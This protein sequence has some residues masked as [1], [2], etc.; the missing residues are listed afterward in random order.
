MQTTRPQTMLRLMSGPA[1]AVLIASCL[2]SAALAAQK[3]ESLYEASLDINGD[4][5]AD[6]AVIVLFGPGRTDFH[7]L[8]KERYGLST[9]ERVE[10]WIFLGKGAQATDLA[11]TPDFVK[12]DIIDPE[13]TPW[14]QPLETNSSGSLMVSAAHQWGA[15][16]DWT[17]VLTI[18][19]RRGELVVAGYD[20]GWSWNTWRAD[21]SFQTLEGECAINFLTGKGT[22]TKDGGE[23]Q[24][25]DGAFE[26]VKLKDWNQTHRPAACDFTVND[27]DD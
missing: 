27:G 23:P 3:T 8:T 7:E 9:D 26:L 1:I 22:L 2:A 24:P 10:L 19:F 4:G 25:V 20:M 12:P 21:D 6:K 18:A 14:V 16:K 11:I 5:K 17:E 13:R 15:S